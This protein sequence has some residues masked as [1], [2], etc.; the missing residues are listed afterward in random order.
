ML[1]MKKVTKNN[2]RDNTDGN[3]NSSDPFVNKEVVVMADVMAIKI[4]KK[5]MMM[6]M[7]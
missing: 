4:F 1:K 6:M 5:R 2:G 7:M 3:S